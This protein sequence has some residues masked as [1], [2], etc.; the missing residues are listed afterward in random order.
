VLRTAITPDI[1][2]IKAL[3]IVVL[4]G[5]MTG[6]I[7]AGVEPMD[8]VRVQLAMMYVILGAV[9]TTTSVTVL[10]GVRQ[11]FTPDHRLVPVPRETRDEG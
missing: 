1:E 6:L 3:G 7:L 11:L 5:A 8:A 4:P 2:R 10:L 9:A